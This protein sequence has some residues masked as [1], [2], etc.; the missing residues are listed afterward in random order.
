MAVHDSVRSN[1]QNFVLGWFNLVGLLILSPKCALGSKK[2]VVLTEFG[3][4]LSIHL[5]IFTGH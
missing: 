5:N 2:L 1:M 3:P 4:L